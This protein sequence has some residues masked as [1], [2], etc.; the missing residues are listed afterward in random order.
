MLLIAMQDSL[1]AWRALGFESFPE[2][3]D[4]SYDEEPDP[5]KRMEVL[6][7]EI[8]KLNNRPIQEL[9]DIYNHPAMI[10]KLKHNK[11]V[12]N[13][14]IKQDPLMRW[15]PIHNLYEKG[16]KYIGLNPHLDEIYLDK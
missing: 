16:S 7:L 8:T 13:N 12:F 2:F 1:K 11:Q 15:S 9:H 3:F 6:K 14:L 4:E 10:E 5:M